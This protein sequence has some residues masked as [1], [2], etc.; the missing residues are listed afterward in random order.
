M[1]V[2]ELVFKAL[3][4]P[5]RTD[6]ENKF[7]CSDRWYLI[8]EQTV[9]IIQ[10]CCFCHTQV[11]AESAVE[12]LDAAAVQEVLCVAITFN[13]FFS[14]SGRNWQFSSNAEKALNLLFLPLP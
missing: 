2:F 10:R 5:E 3:L 4:R 13:I 1:K 7:R 6:V 12:I 11:T 9:H 8:M 14:S